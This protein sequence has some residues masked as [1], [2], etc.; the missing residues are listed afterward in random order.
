MGINKSSTTNY[1]M[2]IVV[3][4]RGFIWI[5]N[6]TENGDQVVIE[7]ARNIRKWGTTQGLGQ[8]VNGPTPDTKLD[9]VGTVRLHQF[10]VIATYDVNS[11]AWNGK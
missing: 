2:R 8:L 5:G 3:G 11:E 7:N 1:P 6:V 4:H 10:G 9:Q